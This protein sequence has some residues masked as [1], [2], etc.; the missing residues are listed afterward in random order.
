MQ[1]YTLA[2][3]DRPIHAQIGPLVYRGARH[4]QHH[5]SLHS[6]R[7]CK[8]REVYLPAATEPVQTQK[9]PGVNM[10]R[11]PERASSLVEESWTQPR[12]A[13]ASA[14]NWPELDA[15]GS[16]AWWWHL[17]AAAPEGA[18]GFWQSPTALTG[19]WGQVCVVC[20]VCVHCTLVKD[21]YLDDLRKKDS[22]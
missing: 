22:D 1:T 6:H 13:H 7:H 15:C 11:D 12:A 10:C 8:E 18:G 4:K 9:D 20:V 21:R 17:H 19:G 5:T 2:Y 16:Q 3:I 14:A